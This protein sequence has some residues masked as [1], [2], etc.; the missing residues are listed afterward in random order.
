[1]NAEKKEVQD[2]L[3]ERDPNPQI[4]HS[5]KLLSLTSGWPEE[6]R[7][8]ESIVVTNSVLC[9]PSFIRLWCLR[10][11]AT[12]PDNF[13]TMLYEKLVLLKSKFKMWL[14]SSWISSGGIFD[15]SWMRL[16]RR[17]TAVSK[18]MSSVRQFSTWKIQCK[19]KSKWNGR[20]FIKNLIIQVNQSFCFS[21]RV[22][23]YNAKAC[24]VFWNVIIMFS[25]EVLSSL[26]TTL[27]GACKVSFK[28]QQGVNGSCWNL[29]SIDSPF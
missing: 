5:L 13:L 11:K 27:G 19:V 8:L 26:E 28:L 15:Q 14:F 4:R 7:A 2:S 18:R 1:M 24:L 6:E 17:T 22:Y 20:F 23:L 10:I 9:F 3:S 29:N 25:A 21:P 16:F 12:T